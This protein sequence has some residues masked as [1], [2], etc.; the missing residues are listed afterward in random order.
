[1]RL[2]DTRRLTGPSL[3]LDDPGAII[4]AE[5]SDGHADA[6]ISAW[7]ARLGE[8]LDALGWGTPETGVRRYSGGVS[9]AFRAPLDALYAATEANEWAF[10]RAVED[11]EGDGEE[12]L[13]DVARDHSLEEIRLNTEAERN[14]SL[15]ALEAAADAHGVSFLWDD[16]HA[17]VGLGTGSRTWPVGEIPETEAIE[18]DALHEV[19]T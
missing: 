10:A 7:T 4:E 17:S 19:P 1:M 12:A 8:A 2:T 6:L 18:W 15:H 13:G 9:L 14:P 11:L 3:L 16:D 5:V